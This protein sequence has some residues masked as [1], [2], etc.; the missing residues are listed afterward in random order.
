MIASH[1]SFS[2]KDKQTTTTEFVT[3][4]QCRILQSIT[5]QQKQLLT[6]MRNILMIFEI[7]IHMKINNLGER[8]PHKSI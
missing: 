8:S 7:D 6:S 5:T 2:K 4:I 3:A 1:E